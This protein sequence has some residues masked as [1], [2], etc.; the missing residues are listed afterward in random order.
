MIKKYGLH[1]VTHFFIT[2]RK[3]LASLL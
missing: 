1:A 2:R 3:H